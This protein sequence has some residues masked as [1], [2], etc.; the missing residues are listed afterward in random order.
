MTSTREQPRTRRTSTTSTE[1]AGRGAIIP[2]MDLLSFRRPTRALAVREEVADAVTAAAT[3]LDSIP[4][5]SPWSEPLPG[6]VWR[7]LYGTEATAP[8]SRGSAMRLG[9]TRRARNFVVATLSGLPLVSLGLGERVPAPEHYA[10]HGDYVEA[11]RA[12][13][14]EQPTWLY[15]S[16]DGASPQ[17]RMAWTLDDLVF[18]PAS[19][20]SVERGSDNFPLHVQRVNRDR[21]TINADNRV[22]IDGRVASDEE[23]ILIPGLTMGIL[24]DG[25]DILRDARAL[26][27]IVRKRLKNPAPT[28][29]LQQ[30]GGEDLNAEEKRALIEGWAAARAGENG[31]VAYSN[32][33][34]KPEEMGGQMDAQLMIEGRNASAVDQARLVGVSASRVDASGVNST[35]SY[36]TEQGRYASDV[37]DLR[38]YTLPIEARLSMDDCVPRGRRVVFDRTDLN[39]RDPRPTG[40]ER[41]D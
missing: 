12:F 3:D 24:V 2:A 20:W 38:L 5:A 29:N 1:S 17:M 41:Q 25:V 28:V 15:R 34:I 13:H 30:T 37:E 19:L 6:I 32:R 10:N 18:H 39:A 21:W 31:G 9:P 7:D 14:A 27:D 16:D 36:E 4:L 22:E 8:P 40:P 33:W 35:L 26:A 23:V 11:L